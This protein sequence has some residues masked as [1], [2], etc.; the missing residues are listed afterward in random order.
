MAHAFF[1]RPRLSL[2][3]FDTSALYIPSAVTRTTNTERVAFRVAELQQLQLG[4]DRKNNIQ[5]GSYLRFA[6]HGTADC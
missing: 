3:L 4:T 2:K 1:L 5:T 6:I